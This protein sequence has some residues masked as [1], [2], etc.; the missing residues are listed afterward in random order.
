METIGRCHHG[1]VV[2]GRDVWAMFGNGET[3]GLL[4]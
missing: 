3:G 1:G 2:Q 4:G